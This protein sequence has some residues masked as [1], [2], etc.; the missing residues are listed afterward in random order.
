MMLAGGGQHSGALLPPQHGA[1]LAAFGGAGGGGAGLGGSH[2]ALS[3]GPGGMM[4]LGAAPTGGP[5]QAI[6]PSSAY[7]SVYQPYSYQQ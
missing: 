1:Y 3:L 2:S 4:G 5:A 6:D 7:Y